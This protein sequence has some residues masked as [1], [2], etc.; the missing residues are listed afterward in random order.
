[1]TKTINISFYDGKVEVQENKLSKGYPYSIIFSF[2]AEWK[3]F[4][5]VAKY[6]AAGKEYYE[7]VFNNVAAIPEECLSVKA[8]TLKVIL[9]QGDNISESKTAVLRVS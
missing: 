7:P 6:V 2:P 5:K 8:F 1:M 3:I 4:K 9:V